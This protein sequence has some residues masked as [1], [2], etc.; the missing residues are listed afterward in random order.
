MQQHI[1]YF[2]LLVQLTCT[3]LLFGQEVSFNCVVSADTIL[4]GNILKV[5]FEVK[6]TQG[7]FEPP[8]FDEW[9]LVSGPNTSSQFSMINGHV[10]Q[11]SS[12]EYILQA[13]EE[14]VLLINSATLNDGEEMLSTEPFIVTILSNPG[15]RQVVPKGYGYRQEILVKPTLP[16]SLSPQDSLKLKLSRLKSTKI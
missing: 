7:Q 6:N 3:V 13:P 14:G 11:S 9:D 10:T 8:S 4:Q 5:K 15:G 2:L 16:D 1:K 12:Y